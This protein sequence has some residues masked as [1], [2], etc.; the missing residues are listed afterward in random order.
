VQVLYVSELTN[1]RK[2]RKWATGPNW[3]PALAARAMPGARFTVKSID[4]NTGSNIRPQP[5]GK[6]PARVRRA[7][8]KRL[9]QAV[10]CARLPVRLRRE[11][12]TPCAAGR[13]TP[14]PSGFLPSGSV[15]LPLP[16]R[17]HIAVLQ[18]TW[19]QWLARLG[20]LRDFSQ[21]VVVVL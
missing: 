21:F 6:P 17:M 5:P 3:A 10:P 13:P 8:G 16:A 9:A 7:P 19:R 2:K 12:E 15:R 20:F 11:Y 18:I 4:C 1:Q 14:C